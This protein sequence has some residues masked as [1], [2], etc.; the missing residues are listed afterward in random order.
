MPGFSDKQRDMSVLQLCLLHVEGKI[1]YIYSNVGSA[2]LGSE[3]GRLCSARFA[4]ARSAVVQRRSEHQ[5]AGALRGER[6]ARRPSSV[7]GGP[8][9]QQLPALRKL[10]HSFRQTPAGLYAPRRSGIGSLSSD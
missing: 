4:L 9:Q 5:A 3:T 6:E 1:G 7:L 10:T 8:R 2:F